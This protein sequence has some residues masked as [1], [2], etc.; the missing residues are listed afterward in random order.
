MNFKMAALILP[1]NFS[2][3]YIFGS[4]VAGCKTQE[5]TTRTASNKFIIYR[6]C[7]MLAQQ[8]HKLS[9]SEKYFNSLH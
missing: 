5:T 2:S 4:L 8:M 3:K 7:P 6:S 9:H 1:P